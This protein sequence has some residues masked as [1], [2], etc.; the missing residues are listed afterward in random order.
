MYP[1]RYSLMLKLNILLNV[2]FYLCYVKYGKTI[3]ASVEL[4]ISL[5]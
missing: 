4:F 5:L 3:K 1:L 2:I